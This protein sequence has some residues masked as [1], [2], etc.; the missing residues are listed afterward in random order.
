MYENQR[1]MMMN[2]SFNME[3][4]NFSIQSV[5]D[6]SLAVSAMKQA[7]VSL[8]GSMRQMNVEKIDDMMAN[9]D[10]MFGE[11]NEINQ[12]LGRNYNTEGIDDETL[13]AELNALGDL[14]ELDSGSA[15]PSY[16]PEVP[17]STSP[18]Q[19]TANEDL[20]IFRYTA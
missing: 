12:M 15:V 2:Q 19:E 14:N 8:K 13:E 7:S 4:A 5:Q 6:A 18:V 1:N 20:S 9:M 17:N 11:A 16:L 3:Q 10:E